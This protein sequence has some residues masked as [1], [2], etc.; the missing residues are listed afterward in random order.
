MPRDANLTALQRQRGLLG[1]GGQALGWATP[2]LSMLMAYAM[3]GLDALGDQLEDPFGRAD[4]DL[5]LDALTRT[6]EIELRAALGETALPAPL[7]P[8][9]FVLT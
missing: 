6:V 5:P 2:L 9:R 3:F 4:N 8:Q 1:S 7:Q